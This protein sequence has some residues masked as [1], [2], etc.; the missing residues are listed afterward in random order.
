[1]SLQDILAKLRN[2][3]ITPK[4]VAYARYSSD[5]QTDASIDAQLRA[6]HDFAQKKFYTHSQ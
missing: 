3:G 5:N 2:N 4:A 1:M 6:I